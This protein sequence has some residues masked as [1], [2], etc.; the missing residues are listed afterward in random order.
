MPPPPRMVRERE[1]LC[2]E[3]GSRFCRAG[4]SAFSSS[5]SRLGD[6][7]RS[8]SPRT[9]SWPGEGHQLAERDGHLRVA[10]PGDR[11]EDGHS[12][13]AQP[14][15]DGLIDGLGAGAGHA[16]GARG[17]M[18]GPLAVGQGGAD[19]DADAA[20]AFGGLVVLQLRLHEH[21][22]RAEGDDVAFGAGD[23]LVPRR[24][25]REA[26]GEARREVIGGGGGGG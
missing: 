6:Q 8:A 10:S 3:R 17:E 20:L 5:R 13:Q 25:L 7:W 9:A 1:T 15:A 11:L 24:Q 18:E 21:G 26:L 2:D 12:G 16:D 19:G 22:V 14:P 23:H 4:R